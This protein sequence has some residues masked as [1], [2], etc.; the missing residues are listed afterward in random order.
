M[1]TCPICRRISRRK[2]RNAPFALFAP[3]CG[4]QD[5]VIRNVCETALLEPTA[6]GAAKHHIRDGGLVRDTPG[7][8]HR[9][10]TFSGIACGTAARPVLF[11]WLVLAFV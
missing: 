2:C 10:G 9:D 11:F 3:T 6:D 5:R 8:E 4:P 7:I 1:V